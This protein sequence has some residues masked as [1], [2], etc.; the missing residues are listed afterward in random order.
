MKGL[1]L[2][3]PFSSYITPLTDIIMAPLSSDGTSQ[4]KLPLRI[5]CL[6]MAYS[7]FKSFNPFLAYTVPYMV[8]IKGLTNFQ[9]TNKVSPIST[10]AVLVFTLLVAPACEYVSYRVLIIS[11]SF[12][13]LLGYLMLRLGTTI[14]S[15]Q[16]MQIISAWSGASY[17]VYQAYLFLLV[18]ENHFQTMTS[19]SQASSSMALFVS[20]ELGQILVLI[21]K[22]L[23]SLLYISMGSASIVCILS[24]MLPKEQSV[25]AGRPHFVLNIFS[26]DQGFWSI[27]RETWADKRL[28]LLSLWWAFALAGLELTLNYGTNL[29]EAIDSASTYN[30]QALAVGT[31]VAVLT[32]LSSVYLKKPMAKLGGFLYIIGSLIYGSMSLGLAYS[33]TI[34]SAYVLYVL[35]LGLEKLLICFVYAQCGSLVKND[36]YALMFSFNCGVGQAVMA[37]LQAVL[38]IAEVDVRG[39]YK[40]LGCYFFGIAFFFSILYG[41]YVWKVRRVEIAFFDDVSVPNLIKVEPLHQ[42][43][44]VDKEDNVM[45]KN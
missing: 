15:L 35:M 4:A 10:Y 22:P 34:W 44:I 41:V 28:Q 25:N 45:L 6:V 40:V 20:S 18:T 42:P 37:V 27:I 7:F 12:A 39:L 29:F 8:Q 32:A 38:E 2:K 24:F 11:G 36:R 3:T 19:I 26:T 1:S 30:G 16:I 21:G 17:F 5:L 23:N 13:C 33:N 9:I 31:A 14:L 43:L